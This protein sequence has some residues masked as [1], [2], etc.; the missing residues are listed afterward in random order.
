MKLVSILLNYSRRT[1]IL[2]IIAGVTPWKHRGGRS[3]SFMT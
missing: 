1:V 2:A 3:R